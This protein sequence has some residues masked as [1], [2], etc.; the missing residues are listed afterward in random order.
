MPHGK[1]W[2]AASQSLEISD[3]FYSM[4]KSAVTGVL[5]GLTGYQLGTEAI[6]GTDDIAAAATRTVL[7]SAILVVVLDFLISFFYTSILGM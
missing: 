4:S 5:V 7:V 1:Y 3:F 2:T 6:R